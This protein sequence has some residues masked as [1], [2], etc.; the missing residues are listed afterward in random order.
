[1]SVWWVLDA[2]TIPK[3]QRS[4]TLNEC[5]VCKCAVTAYRAVCCSLVVWV[6]TSSFGQKNR[7]DM[8]WHRVLD[9]RLLVRGCMFLES[10]HLCAVGYT[11]FLFTSLYWIAWLFCI[12]TSV[13]I[14]ANKSW[15]IFCSLLHLNDTGAFHYLASTPDAWIYFQ[16]RKK[17]FFYVFA[18]KLIVN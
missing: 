7:A 18:F 16:L 5:K 3:R 8:C 4:W 9:G 17:I 2:A 12:I 6:K 10:H 13:D 14:W 11:T 15:S 1:M